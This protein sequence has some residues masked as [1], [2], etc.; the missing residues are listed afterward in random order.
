MPAGDYNKS[1]IG[2]GV[3][4]Q[5]GANFNEIEGLSNVDMNSPDNTTSVYQLLNGRSIQ[6]S[7]SANPYTLTAERVANMGS[8]IFRT[9]SN[10]RNGGTS[11]VFRVDSAPEEPVFTPTVA[12][13]VT[14][15]ISDAGVVTFAGT[16]KPEIDNALAA[17]QIC[18]GHAIKLGGKYYSITQITDADAVSAVEI[19]TWEVPDSDVAAGEFTIVNPKWRYQGLAHVNQVGN[20]SAATDGNPV[21]DSLS[22][23]FVQSGIPWQVLTS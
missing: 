3:F 8:L 6:R 23:G 16:L 15:A 14:C 4:V 18:V 17:R 9:L 22:L 10:A 19:P 1:P 2:T 21:T 20:L 13:N 7:G 11:Q 5:V 12:A